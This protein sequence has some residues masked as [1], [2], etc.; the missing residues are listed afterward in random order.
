MQIQ[1]LL[2]STA[3]NTIERFSNNYAQVKNTQKKTEATQFADVLQNEISTNSTTNTKD[4]LS[5]ITNTKATTGTTNSTTLTLLQSAL[6][7]IQEVT[8]SLS[9]DKTKT[10]EVATLNKTTEQLQHYLQAQYTKSFANDLSSMSA[11]KNTNTTTT[12]MLQ[13]LYG[14][15]D[16]PTS[17]ESRLIN[18]GQ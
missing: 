10:T 2:S 5:I 8:T 17:A 14:N 6:N 12:S 18:I 7:N 9:Q 16:K 4:L 11:L 15:S 3:L 13:S 1:D